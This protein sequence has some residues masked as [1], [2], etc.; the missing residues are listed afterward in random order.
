MRWLLLVALAGLGQ[1]PGLSGPLDVSTLK[2][3]AP[4][5]VTELDLGKMKGELRQLAWS[6]DFTQF[7]VQTADGNKPDEVRHYLVA[8]SGGAVTPAPEEPQWAADYW[9]FKSDRSAP[10]IPDVMID[11]K[12]TLEKVKIG[13]GSAGAADRSAPGAG[14]VSSSGNVERAAESQGENV[15]RLVLFDEAVSVFI[16]QRP[17]PGLQFGWGP[18]GSGAIAFV[19]DSGRLVLLDRGTHKQTVAAVKDAL[20]PAWTMDGSRIAFLEKSGRKKYTLMTAT[21]SPR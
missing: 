6:P 1:T 2:I 21:V 17:I 15:V 14:S 11:V 19:N 12:Q 20:L 5:V 4:T 18:A 10:G 9:R 13:T 7:Y 8:S 16:N 3:D